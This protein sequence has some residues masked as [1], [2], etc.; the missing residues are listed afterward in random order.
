MQLL[1]ING[2]FYL[3]AIDSDSELRVLEYQIEITVQTNISPKF[4]RIVTCK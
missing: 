2:L 4:Y 3:S 1:N